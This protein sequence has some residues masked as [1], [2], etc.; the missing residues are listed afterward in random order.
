MIWML[1]FEGTLHEPD[2][3]AEFYA[4]QLLYDL[5]LILSII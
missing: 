5:K 4:P 3:V 1:S 2:I